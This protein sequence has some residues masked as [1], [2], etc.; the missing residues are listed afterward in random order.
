M[1]AMTVVPGQP[2]TAA[3]SEVPEPVSDEGA[4]L[5]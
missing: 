2:F 3:V 5:V 1:R 4:V